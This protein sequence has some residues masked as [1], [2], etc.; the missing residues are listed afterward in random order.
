MCDDSTLFGKAL[1][2]REV[3]VRES[4]VPRTEIESIDVSASLEELVDLV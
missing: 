2:L 1:N 3:R 4:M